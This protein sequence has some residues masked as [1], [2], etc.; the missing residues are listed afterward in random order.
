MFDHAVEGAAEGAANA[1]FLTTASALDAV[2]VAAM[3]DVD[4][5]TGGGVLHRSGI[6][7]RRS[8]GHT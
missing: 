1:I 7:K 3:L 4:P 8:A 6:E 2:D 5:A